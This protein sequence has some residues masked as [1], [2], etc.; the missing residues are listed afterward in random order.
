MTSNENR[1]T[2]KS[3]RAGI[4]EYLSIFLLWALVFVTFYQFFTRYVLNDSAAWTEEIAQYG[5]VVIVFVGAVIAARKNGHIKMLILRSLLPRKLRYG[6]TVLASLIEA[7]LIFYLFWLSL[8]ILPQMH[9]E[10]MVFADIPLSIIYGAVAI[11]LIMHM[12]YDVRRI[13]GEYKKL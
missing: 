2:E 9:H 11:L 8:R 12:V 10:R 7:A 6:L 1:Q 3:E 4:V 5:L 13:I